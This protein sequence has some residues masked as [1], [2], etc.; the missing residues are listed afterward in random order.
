MEL[1]DKSEPILCV[2]CVLWKKYRFRLM[3]RLLP[4]YVY[5]FQIWQFHTISFVRTNWCEAIMALSTWHFQ[6]T[7][8][9][10]AISCIFLVYFLLLNG[11]I[12][13]VAGQLEKQAWYDALPAVA[14]DY[15][16]HLPAGK[17]DCYY[18]YVQA[19]ATLYVSFQVNLRQSHIS[20]TG[21]W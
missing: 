20:S 19:G 21:R 12:E 14:M 5:N 4:V 3:W 10:S 9:S 7:P 18:Q 17:E 1:L 11:Q 6:N 15:K 13:N 2:L 8:F 16:I